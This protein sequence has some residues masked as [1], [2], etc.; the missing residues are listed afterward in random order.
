MSFVIGLDRSRRFAG[1]RRSAG[2]QAQCPPADQGEPVEL[3]GH[4]ESRSEI[5]LPGHLKRNPVEGNRGVP[6]KEEMDRKCYNLKL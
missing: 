6:G 3:R 2:E 4:E 1:A 5:T